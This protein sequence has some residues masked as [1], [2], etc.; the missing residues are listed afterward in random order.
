M[1]LLQ[2]DVDLDDLYEG[3]EVKIVVPTGIEPA[4]KV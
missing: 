3:G 1:S 2:N 4:S